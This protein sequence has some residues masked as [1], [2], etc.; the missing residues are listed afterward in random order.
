MSINLNS[1]F[2]QD[3]K[4]GLLNKPKQLPSKYLYNAKGDQFFQEKMACPAY[5]ISR[6]EYQIIVDYK[7]NLRNIFGNGV[8]SFQ[9]IDLGAGDGSKTKVLLEHFVEQKESFTYC[10]IDISQNNLSRLTT[11]LKQCFNQLDI[12]AFQGDYFKALAKIPTLKTERKVVLF[13]GSTIGNFS[14]VDRVIFLKE[15]TKYLQPEDILFT[16]FDLK[17]D[18]QTIIDAY[19]L[20][21]SQKLCLN[22]L[23]RINKELDGNFD[24]E[25]FSHYFTYSPVTGLGESYLLSKQA[26]T[27]KFSWLEQPIHFHDWEPIQ[28]NY[29]Q[30][31]DETS[32]EELAQ[33]TGF[34]VIKNFSDR[35]NYLLD[36]V[37]L[38]N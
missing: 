22:I 29:H 12:Q 17:K 36:S 1:K 6:N 19:T 38:F 4:Q 35:E 37:W 13:M 5:Y 9:L 25:S 10:P 26:Q 32:I 31:F 8:E 20:E 3:I 24:T 16:G 27:V 18:P 28:I 11:K 23:D 7:E 21:L 14:N 15:L 30:K 34:E 33:K 2:A